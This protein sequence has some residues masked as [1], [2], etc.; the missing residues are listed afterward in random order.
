MKTTI[1]IAIIAMFILS[2]VPL[3]FAE[4]SDVNAET[5][6]T[7]SSNNSGTNINA[8]MRGGAR[9]EIEEIREKNQERLEKIADLDKKQIERLSNLGVRNVEKIAELKKERLE[10]L[11]K[12]SQKK[13]E[14]LSELEKD[15]LEKVSDLNETEMN[16]LASLGRWRLKEIA[17][18][19][20]QRLRMELKNIRLVKVK[21]AEDMDERNVSDS[22]IAELREKFENAREDF[23]KAKEDV[24]SSRKELNEA[25]KNKNSNK[26]INASKKYLSRAA[27]AMVSHLEKIKSK[28]QESKNIPED[29]VKEIVA[30]IDAEIAKINSIKAEAQ[31]A[32]TKE[33]VKEAAKKL[34]EEWNKAKSLAKIH[35]ERIVS[36]RVEGIINQGLVLEKRL[37]DILDKAKE[38]NV[39]INVSAEISQF[40]EKIGLSRE[41]Y[42]QAQSNI[43]EALDLRAQGEPADSD[44]IKALLEDANKLLGEAR[45]AIKEAQSI[46]KSI[47]KKIKEAMP[48]ADLSSDAEVDVESATA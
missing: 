12:L 16:K 14:R 27:D 23:D 44:K 5:G 33:Q 6:V 13:I 32:T 40:S 26:T 41:K 8:G 34:R 22:K 39:S 42:K 46:L 15:K 30:D 25:I 45:D 20:I 3:A 1:S 24:E 35:A 28:I 29:R 21:K 18:E 17:K 38:K 9:L 43:S 36:A 11:T 7:A 48:G 19:D 2:L 4:E 31:A 47:V 10:R 37:D